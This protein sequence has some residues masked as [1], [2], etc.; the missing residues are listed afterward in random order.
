MELPESVS[1]RIEECGGVEGLRGIVNDDQS[2]QEMAKRY[3]ALG[4]PGR[5][6]IVK[7]LKKTDLCVCVIKKIT[8][9]SDSQ[10]SYHLAILKEAD[11]IESCREGNYIIYSYN[12]D[13]P[14]L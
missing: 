8:G 1:K 10:L 4:D 14:L 9:M 7:C 12:K 13:A 5:L 11:L 2:L 6:A 3:S